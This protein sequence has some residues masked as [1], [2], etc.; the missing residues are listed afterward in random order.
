M[1]KQS[2]LVERGGSCPGCC[3][4]RIELT[5]FRCAAIAGRLRTT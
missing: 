2:I 3:F 5:R 4:G 1:N